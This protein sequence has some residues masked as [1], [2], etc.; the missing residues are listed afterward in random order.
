MFRSIAILF[1]CLLTISTS[2]AQQVLE[3]DIKFYGS[4][5]EK[6]LNQA[7][8][9]IYI[10]S[11]KVFYQV[12]I[13][14]NHHV[15]KHHKNEPKEF[16]ATLLGV[17]QNEFQSIT[18]ILFQHYRD[19]LLQK[20]FEIIPFDSVESLPYFTTWEKHEGGEI[21]ASHIEGYLVSRPTGYTHFEHPDH[22]KISFTDNTP[23]LSKELNDAIVLDVEFVL[24]FVH[25]N[26]SKSGYSGHSINDAKLK[27]NIAP[28]IGGHNAAATA[29]SRIKVVYGNPAGIA[30]KSNLVYTIKHPVRVDSVMTSVILDEKTENDP[31]PTYYNIALS[32]QEQKKITHHAHCEG[33]LYKE[34]ALSLTKSFSKYALHKL[35]YFSGVEE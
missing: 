31:I 27:F 18:D 14:N 1:C 4:Y 13:S 22:Q 6:K 3:K 35:F 24:P 2:V 29:H 20:G 11:F 9:K 34:N 17:D 8:K 16:D 19:T 15:H 25:A 26:L 12:Y 23:A 28:T 30:A 7:P 5:G 10:A 33:S 32:K 21:K